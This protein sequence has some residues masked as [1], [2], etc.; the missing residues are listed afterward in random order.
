MSE[1]K[2][3]TDALSGGTPNGETTD[4]KAKYEEAQKELASARVEQGR[5]KKLADEKKALEAK[6]AELDSSRRT[7]DVIDALPE[8][9]REALPEDYAKGASIVAQRTVDAA[10]AARDAEIAR[11]KAR[12]EESARAQ[13]ASRIEQ[14]FP[15]FI[16]SAAAA[17]GD[18]SEAWRKYQRYNAQ[19]IN[20][21]I[22]NCDFDVLSWH[23]RNFYTNELGVPPP[24]GRT[25]AA[26]PD[27]STTGGGTSVAMQPGK[28]Y[29]WDE[30]DALYDEIERL[31]SRGD[32]EGMK[33]I[34]DEI[35]K[36]QREGR[37]K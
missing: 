32:K 17:G 12:N 18:K 10:L 23:I 24:S 3:I 25:G 34:S 11:L 27:P 33:R 31:R 36:A 2:T 14:E 20:S 15:G 21:A 9:V 13:F 30:V 5:V 35:E 26:A 28:V 29:T 22:E 19:S 8:D 1:K 7:R 6:I 37:V 16:N 4:W